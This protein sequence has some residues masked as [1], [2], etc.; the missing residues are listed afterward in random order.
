VTVDPAVLAAL[1]GI[2]ADELAAA[3]ASVRRI[4][5]VSDLEARRRAHREDLLEFA[6]D[7]LP[8]HFDRAIRP[9]RFHLDVLDT[10]RE[11]GGATRSIRTAWKAPR[12]GA[13]ST[14]FC[15]LLPVA[16]AC[17][18]DLFDLR[19]LVLV[20]TRYGLAEEDVLAVRNLCVSE[21]VQRYYGD[22]R[23]R[24]WKQ[25]VFVTSTGVRVQAAGADQGNRGLR[26]P[27]TGDR[28]DAVVVDDVDKDAEGP[29]VR[30]KAKVWLSGAV[31]GMKGVG[32]PM[33]ALAAG[34]CIDYDT[35]IHWLAD[36]NPAFAGR[37]YQA[38]ERWPDER[39]GLWRQW[40]DVWRRDNSPGKLL[41]LAFYEDHREEMDAG[42]EVLWSDGEPLYELMEAYAS[43]GPGAFGAEKQQDPRSSE[44]ALVMPGEL[45][46]WTEPGTDWTPPEGVLVEPPESWAESGGVLDPASTAKKGAD[47]SVALGGSRAPDGRIFLRRHDMARM[48]E[49]E[50]PPRSVDVVEA[51]DGTF[52]Q[53]ETVGGFGLLT[54]PITREVRRRG[55][56][57][58]VEEWWPTKKSD[59]DGDAGPK[60]P[61]AKKGHRLRAMQPLYRS[62]DV[63]LHRSMYG[64]PRDQVLAVRDDGDSVDHDDFPDAVEMLATRLRVTGASTMPTRTKKARRARQV[65]DLGGGGLDVI[66]GGG[67]RRKRG[68]RDIF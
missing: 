38:M 35:V 48:R 6:Y 55:L 20:R 17:M 22:L 57:V 47:F 31:L 51:V 39:E 40:E 15:T 65:G 21:P 59:R 62:G 12:G 10:F 50:L 67:G 3:H 66:D 49:H 61:S 32:R 42:A 56:T 37:T 64:L 60:P 46:W 52:L 5:E 30:R 8:D 33:H 14:F 11:M 7:C 63:V 41:A 29:A 23:G 1:Q 25:G 16:A 13:K 18:P 44:D 43:M 19:F 68:R 53:V 26:D 58:A 24:I 27:E 36:E 2:P 28:P 54:G 45:H 34:T 9:S 4:G